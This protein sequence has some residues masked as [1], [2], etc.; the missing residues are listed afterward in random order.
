MTLFIQNNPVNEVIIEDKRIEYHTYSK[1][2]FNMLI[3]I[4]DKGALIKQTRNSV[5]TKTGIP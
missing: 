4:Q 1:G 5:K 2:K 3:H